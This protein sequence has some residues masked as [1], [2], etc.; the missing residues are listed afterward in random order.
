[1]TEPQS[2]GMTPVALFDELNAAQ[3]GEAR[4][5]P[6]ARARPVMPPYDKVRREFTQLMPRHLD[7][8]EKLATRPSRGEGSPGRPDYDRSAMHQ[9]FCDHWNS[10]F[11]PLRG[12]KIK[13]VPSDEF[14]RWWMI[15][16][17]LDLVDERRRQI[18]E[19]RGF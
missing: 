7:W 2:S 10:F 18:E 15:N 6:V 5:P 1:M 17:L 14:R 19:E 13:D 12:S 3:T 4:R 8:V 11:G 9:H 16:N